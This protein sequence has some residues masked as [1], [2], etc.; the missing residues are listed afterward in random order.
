[1]ELV[2]QMLASQAASRP[3]KGFVSR[4]DE[5]RSFAE[6]DSASSRL[7]AFLRERGVR[8]GDRVGILSSKCIEEVVA[9]FAI[10]KAGA[11]MVHVNPHFKAEQVSRL[12]AHS[13]MKALLLHGSKGAVI[14][15]A[16]GGDGPLEL[17]VSLDSSGGGERAHALD[18]ILRASR[19]GGGDADVREDDA[20][21]IIYTSGSTGAPKGIVVTHRIL[22]DATV[23]SAHVLGNGPDDRLI[24]V[25]PFSFDGALSQLF[26]M[27][28]AGG[29]VHLQESALPKDIVTTLLE[30]RVTGFHAMPTLW[31]ML[32]QRHSP[33]RRHS[34]P[35]LRYVSII[36]ERFPEED[37]RTLREILSTTA[38]YMMYGTTEAFRSTY[39]PPAELD[40]KR[41]SVGIPFP[42]VTITIRDE[43]GE[44]VAPGETGEIV[45]EGSF[46][47][48]GYWSDPAA[49][50]RAFRSG[51]LFT[52][53]LG[54]LDDDG[55]LYFVGR[56]DSML[57]LSGYRVSPEEIEAC[58]LRVPGVGEALVSTAEDESRNTVVKALLVRSGAPEVAADEVTRYCRAQ[59]PYYMVPRIVEFVP[60]LPKTGTFKLSRSNTP[61]ARRSGTS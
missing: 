35:D 38:F 6:V 29:S 34:Y 3:G 47:S 22:R 8:R 16:F 21:A 54:R 23:H 49:T 59:L 36:G 30:R 9:I 50:A 52:G 14:E 2:H 40:R 15:Q 46:V 5:S 12:V 43:Q 58:L 37:L 10:L 26:T 42:G 24:S 17:V 39:L 28:Y 18:E 56:K 51:A 31:R 61:Q 44:R 11:T 13:G 27:A 41:G 33:L 32:L 4:G 20:A 1:M 57:K 45:H 7:A 19:D 55:Y 53:D 48:P 25:T 60:E